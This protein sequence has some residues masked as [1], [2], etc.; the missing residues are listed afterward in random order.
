M[1]QKKLTVVFYKMSLFFTFS[2]ISSHLITVKFLFCFVLFFKKCPSLHI[3]ETFNNYLM[4]SVNGIFSFK[5][6]NIAKWLMVF[7]IH[8]MNDLSII[9]PFKNLNVKLQ[10]YCQSIEINTYTYINI[11]RGREREKETCWN[12]LE[13]QALI[14][15]SEEQ[16]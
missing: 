1:K 7:L 5:L 6:P 16:E 15:E 14:V 3:N 2:K 10:S 12:Y 9:K 4:I 13:S 8:Q 11:W